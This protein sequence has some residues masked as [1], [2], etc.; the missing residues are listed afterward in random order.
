VLYV[1]AGLF[2]V[3]F[4]ISLLMVLDIRAKRRAAA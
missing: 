4:A 2:V 1:F 3:A